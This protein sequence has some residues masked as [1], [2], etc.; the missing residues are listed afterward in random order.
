MLSVWTRSKICFLVKGLEA[1]IS[2]ETNRGYLF[3]FSVKDRNLFYRV[4]TIGN[5]FTR[6]AATSKNIIDVVHEMKSIAIFH[7][8]KKKNPSILFISCFLPFLGEALSKSSTVFFTLFPMA[9][10]SA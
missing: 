8:K 1:L 7:K 3:F 9:T 5:I 6:G 4:D 10:P 2:H